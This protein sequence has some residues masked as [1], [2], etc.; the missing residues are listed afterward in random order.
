MNSKPGLSIGRH[1]EIG[2][3][4]AAIRDRL[5]TLAVEI[6]NAY[7]KASKAPRLAL[8]VTDPLDRLRSEL[9][10][11]MF[12]QHGGASASG[13]D[14]PPG[15]SIFTY[16]PHPSERGHPVCQACGRRAVYCRELDRYAHLDGSD[17]APCWRRCSRGEAGL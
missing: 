6:A 4:L 8:R 1:G 15:V 9:E 12:R 13:R 17:N 10:G 3:E 11:E 14:D 5:T 2:A 16:Y 7:P